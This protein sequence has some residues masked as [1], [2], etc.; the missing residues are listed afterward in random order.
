MSDAIKRIQ[1]SPEGPDALRTF[2]AT[3]KIGEPYEIVFTDANWQ[4]CKV[5]L[6]IVQS[7]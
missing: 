6:K 7:N 1:R 2:V 4:S 3:A 5:T